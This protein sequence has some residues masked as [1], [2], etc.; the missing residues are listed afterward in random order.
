MH[1]SAIRAYLALGVGV[2]AISWSAILVHWADM[3]GPVSA[4]WRVSLAGLALLIWSGAA[5]PQFLNWKQLSWAGCGGVFFA[6]DLALFNTAATHANASNVT[7]LGNNTPIFAGLLSWLLWGRR[8]GTR[9][10]IG[11][12]C[13]LLG[14]IV[15]AGGD[16]LLSASFGTADLMALLASLC[17]AFYLLATERVRS[18]T[19]VLS[20]LTA[21]LLATAIA[22]LAFNAAAGLPMAIHDGRS[23]AAVFG[24]AILPQLIGYLAITYA[25]G[26]LSATTVSMGLTAQIPGTAV[27][28]ALL[29]NEHLLMHQLLGGGLILSAIWITLRRGPK[30][31]VI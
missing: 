26:H 3:P 14:T 6:A 18:E 4:F 27:L 20:F 28:A 1:T 7:V 11:L 12:G 16:A 17:F 25:L 22:L 30:E 19:G 9:L 29:L 23:W 10:W 5:R 31:E 8:P 2:F 15:L 24:L 21:A 13:A